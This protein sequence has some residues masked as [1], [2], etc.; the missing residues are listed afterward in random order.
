MLPDA[1]SQA[2]LFSVALIALEAARLLCF[3]MQVNGPIGGCLAI[4]QPAIAALMFCEEHEVDGSNNIGLV[5]NLHRTASA[6]CNVRARDMLE[7]K[8]NCFK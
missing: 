7:P 6:R 3:C 5:R 1:S 4:R 2:L 8:Q